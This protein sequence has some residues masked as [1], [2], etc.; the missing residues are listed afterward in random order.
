MAARLIKEQ[1]QNLDNGEA[2]APVS[3]ANAAVGNTTGS[4]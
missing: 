1:P 2:A 4:P 3:S